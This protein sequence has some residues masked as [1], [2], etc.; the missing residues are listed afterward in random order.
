MPTFNFTI[1]KKASN[2]KNISSKSN[3]IEKN[4]KG[5]VFIDLNKHYTVDVDGK[6]YNID[7]KSFN[8]KGVKKVYRLSKGQRIL[9]IRGVDNTFFNQYP[10]WCPFAPGN[11]VEGNV[12]NIGGNNVF[13]IKK[14]YDELNNHTAIK[15]LH[16]YKENWKKIK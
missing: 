12:I 16:F 10:F 13:H 2:S 9:Y 14:V 5:V 1:T 4:V 3:I 15:A 11:C 7:D 6:I 8:T